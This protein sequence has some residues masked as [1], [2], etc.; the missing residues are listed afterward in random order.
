MLHLCV[1]RVFLRV[2]REPYDRTIRRITKNTKEDTKNT[3]EEIQKIE[4]A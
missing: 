4:F 3:M 2:L 1:L